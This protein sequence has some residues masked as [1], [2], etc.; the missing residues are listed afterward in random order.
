MTD[1]KSYDISMYRINTHGGGRTF[2]LGF[3]KPKMVDTLWVHNYAMKIAGEQKTTVV[4]L[5]REA[6]ELARYS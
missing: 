4:V 5:D 1:P 2:M 6:K 3:T